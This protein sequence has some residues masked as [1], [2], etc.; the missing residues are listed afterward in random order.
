MDRISDDLTLGND[1]WEDE[2]LAIAKE[3]KRNGY[4]VS[5]SGWLMKISH[6][7]TQGYSIITEV[8]WSKPGDH[9]K[10]LTK[11]FGL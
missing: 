6:K 9:P 4:K 8:D 7:D 10:Q 11:M 3:L 1:E 2:I 5:S